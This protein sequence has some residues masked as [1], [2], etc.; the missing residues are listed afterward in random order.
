MQDVRIEK[1]A[2][3]LVNY[4]V[5]IKSG[6]KVAI[7]GEILAEPL[8]KAIYTKVLQAG[9]HPFLLVSPRGIDE[10][11]YRFASD[12][13]LR[14]VPPPVK[15]IMDTYDVRISIGAESNTRALTSVDPAK[16]VLRQQSRTELMRTFMQRAASGELRWTYAI[17][18]TEAYAQD[19]EMSLSEYEDLVF[20]ACLGDV[21]DPV[22]Y[23]KRFSAWQQKIIEWL[24]GKKKIHIVAPETDLYLSVEGRKFL[25]CD[26]HE[27]MPD[28]E[29]FTGPVED[30][31]EGH[32]YFSYPAI[33]N[34]REVSGIRLW[35]EKGQVV[36]AT[37][38]KNQ[39][40]LLKTLD[41]DEGARRVGEFA[42]GTNRGITTF[43]RQILFDEKINGSFHMALGASYPETGGKNESAIHWDMI[44]DMR[45][46]GE[47]TVDGELFYKDG[48]FVIPI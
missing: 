17:F 18:P 1:M 2:E 36:K 45:N 21:N 4:S 29:I 24:N 23:W 25:N 43:T 3:L 5:G 27:N 33:E 48:K 40:F 35:F 10:I 34:G 22:G 26:G 44:C 19:A 6:D 31:I 39:E 8:L 28:G 46:G 15:L 12:E 11:L 14:H 30:S 32:V 42:F 7:Q 16:I 13:Q 47:V 20:T 9:G 41:T 38:E 37:A